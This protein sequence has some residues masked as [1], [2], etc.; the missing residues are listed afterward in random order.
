MIWFWGQRAEVYFDF[1]ISRLIKAYTLR[2]N[3]CLG[4]SSKAFSSTTLCPFT[5]TDATELD[6]CFRVTLETMHYLLNTSRYRLGRHLSS[7]FTTIH[8]HFVTG[9]LRLLLEGV[10]PF[11]SLR[12]SDYI[13][14]NNITNAFYC[15]T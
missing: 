13:N 3:I 12:I 9:I 6:Y 10:P 4:L 15:I 14:H 7:G 5:W 11:L 8:S 1:Y 2:H